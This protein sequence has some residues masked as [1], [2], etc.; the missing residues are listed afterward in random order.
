M[1]KVAFILVFVGIFAVWLFAAWLDNKHNWQLVAWFNGKETNPFRPNEK[2]R[3]Q[4]ELA[5]KDKQIDELKERIQVLEK[6][7]T[8]PAYELNQKLNRL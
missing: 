4:R 3:T 7:V 8:E 2:I 1:E 5:N 6:I